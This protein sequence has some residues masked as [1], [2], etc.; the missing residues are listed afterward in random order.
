[1]VNI[2]YEDAGIRIR[3]LREKRHMTREILSERAEISAKF[4]YE[5]EIGK[6]GFS[7]ITAKNL[8]NALGTNCDYLLQGKNNQEYCKEIEGALNLFD[9]SKISDVVQLLVLIN[10]LT[11]S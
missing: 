1:M 4:L 2:F 10:N 5:I 7:A 9:C 6:K 11:N 3:T 8:A